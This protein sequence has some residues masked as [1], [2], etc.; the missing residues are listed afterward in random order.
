MQRVSSDISP[1]TF[2]T[3]A[4]GFHERGDLA[5]AERLY[6]QIL[7][8]KPAPSASVQFMV[9]HMLGIIRHQQGRHSEAIRLIGDAL[10]IKPD[11]AEVQTVYAHVLQAAGRIEEAVD[12]YGKALAINPAN[13]GA[14][15]N[16]GV[17]LLQIKRFGEALTCFD[18]AIALKP[19]L[20]EAW[21]NRGVALRNLKRHGEALE[22]FDQAIS[23]NP[24]SAKS[25]N[26]RGGA[27]HSLMRMDEAE[28]SIRKAL[29]LAP[30]LPEGLRALGEVLCENGRTEEA[31]T[32][33][34]RHAELTAGTGDAA[35]ELPHKIRH[36][37]EQRDYLQGKGNQRPEDGARITGAT[38]NPVNR[39]D[40]IATRWRSSAPQI[41]VIDD[42]LTPEALDKLRG[43]CLDAPI[44]RRIYKEGYLGAIP[45]HGFAAP[46]L[47]QIADELRRAYPAVFAEHPLCY[48][49]AFKY[50]GNQRGTQIHADPAAINV[51]FWITPDEAN[52]NPE[53][54]GMVIWDV[55]APANWDFDT[56]NADADANQ[57]FVERMNSK[58]RVIP[59]RANRAVIF[60]SD[61]FHKTDDIAFKDGYANRRINVTFLYGRRVRAD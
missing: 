35:P 37:E 57:A 52:L 40:D 18:K 1:E 56:Y 59:Y 7:G 12:A 48:L 39:A 31:L 5:E 53:K 19:D 44:W 25:W 50:D 58:P 23:L 16:Q 29:E 41:L 55:K 2:C 47:A 11:S 3:I 42:F 46:L 20:A 28:K 10:T 26:G 4:L 49:W 22:S 60:D 36:D 54:G 9:G 6:L 32:V 17:R 14:F 45:E 51:N 33:F 30:D 13:V 15:N 43:F 24:A 34:A 8:A 27:L 61:L 38:I 21:N